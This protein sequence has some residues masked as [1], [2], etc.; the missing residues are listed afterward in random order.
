MLRVEEIVGSRELNFRDGPVNPA[1]NRLKKG[2]L[3]K[4]AQ[5]SKSEQFRVSLVIP[6]AKN[7]SNNGPSRK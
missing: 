5:I 1:V 3:R 2:P 6:K 7:G 4:H